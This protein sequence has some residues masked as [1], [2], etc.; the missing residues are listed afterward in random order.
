MVFSTFNSI[1]NTSAEKSRNIKF[2]WAN[3]R[4]IAIPS[5]KNMLTVIKRKP[6]IQ[7]EHLCEY[8]VTGQKN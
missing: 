5:G 7:F 4:S 8:T 1:E 6:L 2:Y 3:L